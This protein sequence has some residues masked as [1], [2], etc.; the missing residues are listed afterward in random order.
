MKAS[1][2]KEALSV[3]VQVTNSGSGSKL[4]LIW[5]RISALVPIGAVNVSS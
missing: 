2:G 5:Q 1:L 3:R 4:L